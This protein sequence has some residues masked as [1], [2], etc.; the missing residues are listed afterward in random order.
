M[1]WTIYS[2]SLMRSILKVQNPL[3][4]SGALWKTPGAK[5]MANHFVHSIGLEISQHCRKETRYISKRPT[6]ALNNK[7]ESNTR[8]NQ[9]LAVKVSP[10]VS[11]RPLLY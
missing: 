2:W 9:V 6:I 11:H 4:R 1:F 3:Q 5:Q 10:R 7:F 8:R